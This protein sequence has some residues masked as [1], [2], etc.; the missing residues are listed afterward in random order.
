MAIRFTQ[1]RRLP[2][3]AGPLLSEAREVGY[4]SYNK[5]SGFVVG[6]V[7]ETFDGTRFAGAFMENV[8]YGLT[9]CAEPAAI[10]AANTAGHRDIATIAIVGGDPSDDQPTSP[11]CMPCGRC[12]QF[13][14]EVAA[15]N[16][17]DIEIYC[18]NLALEG[19]L[20]TTARELLPFA[21][22]DDF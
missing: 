10:L 4:R 13:I 12:R 15:L 21:F 14:W 6:A 11:P 2:T 18:S 9:I 16:R 1:D 22:G 17:R 5:Y 7:V 3:S 8:S 20:L 19:V